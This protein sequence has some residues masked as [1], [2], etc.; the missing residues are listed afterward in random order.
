MQPGENP[1]GDERL[2]WPVAKKEGLPSRPRD[3]GAQ[4]LPEAMFAMVDLTHPPLSLAALGSSA[5]FPLLIREGRGRL[6]RRF[7]AA[8]AG[9]GRD[10]A[11]RITLK[12][13]AP[14]QHPGAA[15]ETRRGGEAVRRMGG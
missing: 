12:H 2:D 10:P 7:C 14:R 5:P 1:A 15:S 13:R 3:R 11:R 8:E 9:V 4:M 6:R